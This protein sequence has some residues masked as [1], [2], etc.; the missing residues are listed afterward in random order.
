M[1]GYA[2]FL[3]GWKQRRVERG[4]VLSDHA[5]WPGL[6]AAIRATGAGRILVTHGIADPLVRYLRALGLDA[7]ALHLDYGEE[8]RFEATTASEGQA[9]A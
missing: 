3:D 2:I 9:E 8:D 6:L 1:C 7:Q 5:D 4:F